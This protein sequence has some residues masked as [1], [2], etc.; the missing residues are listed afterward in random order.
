MHPQ[1]FGG[2]GKHLA[3]LL[4]VGELSQS[5]PPTDSSRVRD[6]L[7]LKGLP[8]ALSESEFPEPLSVA[9]QKLHNGLIVAV[10]IHSA[11]GEHVQ[12]TEQAEHLV[13]SFADKLGAAVSGA[14]NQRD[15]SDPVVT[16]EDTKSTVS[17]LERLLLIA[18]AFPQ[19]VKNTVGLQI[20]KTNATS[21]RLPS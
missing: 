8:G 3:A 6:G 15:S 10:S 13:V 16:L 1:S 14:L 19:G 4:D 9:V 21:Q 20:V 7:P 11:D 12:A 2:M 5:I 17:R 18:C